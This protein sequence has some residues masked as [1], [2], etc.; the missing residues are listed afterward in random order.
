[1]NPIVIPI[2]WVGFIGAVPLLFIRWCAEPRGS[3]ARSSVS[4]Y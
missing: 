4:S 3:S 2:I 1:M